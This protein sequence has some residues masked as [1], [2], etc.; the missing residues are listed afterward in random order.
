MRLVRSVF[1]IPVM[2]ALIWGCTQDAAGPRGLAASFSAPQTDFTYPKNPPRVEVS[3]ETVVP[4]GLPYCR[5]T[6]GLVLT[7]YSPSFLRTA[8]NFPTG[9]PS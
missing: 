7:C 5:T 6:T 2:A 3:P 1:T 9:R 4:T 8:Y